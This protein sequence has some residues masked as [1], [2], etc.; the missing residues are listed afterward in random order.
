MQAILN[1]RIGKNESITDDDI[2]TATF[3]ARRKYDR[4]IDKWRKD[5]SIDASTFSDDLINQSIAYVKEPGEINPILKEIQKRSEEKHEEHKKKKCFCT[6]ID[7]IIE[8]LK[9]LR[10]KLKQFPTS[11][12]LFAAVLEIE[13][14]KIDVRKKRWKH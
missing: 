7:D 5:S 4:K 2:E 9:T 14:D 13:Q 3:D 6:S 12:Y 8:P 11:K 1:E 10:S